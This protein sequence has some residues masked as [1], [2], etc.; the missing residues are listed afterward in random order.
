MC[1]FLMYCAALVMTLYMLMHP[2]ATTSTCMKLIDDD[3]IHYAHAHKRPAIPGLHALPKPHLKP[4]INMVGG[5]G[6]GTKAMIIFSLK[7][8]SMSTRRVFCVLLMLKLNTLCLAVPTLPLPQSS[9]LAAPPSHS[10]RLLSM[11]LPFNSTNSDP[12]Q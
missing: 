9:S 2:Q 3:K 11:L 5:P 12:V 8:N 1:S 6:L 7:S 4:C 10:L